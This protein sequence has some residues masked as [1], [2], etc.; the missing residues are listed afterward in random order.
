[1]CIRDRFDDFAGEARQ[2]GLDF[3]DYE[4]GMVDGRYDCKWYIRI[5]ET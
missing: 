4:P 3:K 1:M 5:L 2:Q